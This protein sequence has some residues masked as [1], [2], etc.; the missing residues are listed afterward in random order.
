MKVLH[1]STSA[2]HFFQIELDGK[3]YQ[4]TIH[5]DEKGKFMDEEVYEF[6][7][8]ELASDDDVDKI[9]N[10]IDKNWDNLVSK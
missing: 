5:T 10:Y 1:K 6:P 9:I 7:G 8:F 4:A 3:N 2:T